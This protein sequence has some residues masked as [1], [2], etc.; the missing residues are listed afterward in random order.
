MKTDKRLM[1]AYLKAPVIEFDDEDK[2]IIF[3]DVHRGDN[4]MS[5]EFAHNQNIYYYALKDYYNKGYTY[6]EVGDGDELWEHAKFSHIRSA[7]SDAFCILREFFLEDRFLLLY[8]NHNMYLKD[9]KYV[10]NNLHEFY[11]EFLNERSLLFPDITVYESII[12]KYKETGQEFLLLHGH[13]GDIMNDQLWKISMLGLR[14]FWKFMHVIGL[15]NPSSPAKNRIKRHKIELNFTKW[16]EKE[17]KHII[18]GHTHRPKFPKQG[19]VSY[20]NTG[21]CIHPRCINGIEIYNGEIMLVD[22][23]IRPNDLGEL[24]I[25]KQNIRGPVKIDTFKFT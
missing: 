24:R 20:F 9:P 23:R 12:L 22:W 16:I 14:Y 15:Q 4:S 7:H 17:Q 10:Q 6:I 18:C 8:G 3:G 5:D 21:C 19:E 2:F 1:Q 11:D 25:S 13:Q